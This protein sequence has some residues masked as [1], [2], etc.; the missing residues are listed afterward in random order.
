M[1]YYFIR[2]LYTY[3]ILSHSINENNKVL[4]VIHFNRRYAG[5]LQLLTLKF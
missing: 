3:Y 1:N 2:I 4:K 5:L